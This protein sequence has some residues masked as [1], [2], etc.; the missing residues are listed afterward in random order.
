[1][2]SRDPI[3][4][5]SEKTN[6]DIKAFMESLHDVDKNSPP[7][8]VDWLDWC[9]KINDDHSVKD[10]DYAVNPGVVNSYHLIPEIFS[11]STNAI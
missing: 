4:L 2:N 9:R 1:M 6:E 3:E 11:N 7:S 8:S 10:S 5:L